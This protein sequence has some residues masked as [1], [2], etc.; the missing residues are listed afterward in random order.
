M[1]TETKSDL[2]RFYEFVG[3]IVRTGQG[4]FTPEDCVALWRQ[5][6]EEM[7]ES[8]AAIKRGLEDMEAGRGQPVHEAF[9]DIR[10]EIEKRRNS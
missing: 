5:I 8:L 10:R 9:A 4:E 3:G 2:E 6:H 1:A 7:D